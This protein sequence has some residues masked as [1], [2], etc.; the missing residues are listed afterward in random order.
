M[1]RILKKSILATV[2]LGLLAAL[3]FVLFPGLK[4]E[5]Y[6]QL[7]PKLRW[8]ISYALTDKFVVGMVYFVE[9]DRQLLLV[10]HS[11]QDKW[12]LPGGWVERHESFE[13][14]ARRELDEELDIRID[15]FEV[16][17]VNKVPRS[18]I[19]NIAIRGRL[20]DKRVMIRDSEIFGYRFFDLD[21]LPEDIL[22]THKPYIRRYLE[23][24]QA[25]QA[26]P[27][28][29]PEQATEP[30]PAPAEASPAQADH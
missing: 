7:S 6:R 4:Y 25:P 2:L 24:Y 21:Q 30:D 1:R 3:A 10:R 28:Q 18:G 8:N 5:I 26:I 12:A 13:E 16:L 23:S 15:D 27:A 22:Y 29:A 17:E 9:R 20:Q 11:Y 19:I 14:S